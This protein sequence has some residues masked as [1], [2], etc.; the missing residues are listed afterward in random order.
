[1][2]PEHVLTCATEVLRLVRAQADRVDPDHLERARNQLAVRRLDAAERPYRRLEEAAQD[3]FVHNRLRSL[4]EQQQAIDTLQPED[5]R[6]C[7]ERM[8]QAT[9]A[10]VVAGRLE[11]G[12]PDKLHALAGA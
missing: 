2:A 10:L 1:M 9:P 3:L 12:L 5:V 8:L 6:Q 4:Q 7:F 11:K